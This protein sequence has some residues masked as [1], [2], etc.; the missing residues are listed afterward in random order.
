[1]LQY[2]SDNLPVAALKFKASAFELP[3]FNNGECFFFCPVG[4]TSWGNYVPT[5]NYSTKNSTT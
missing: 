3:L 4:T 2:Q 1:M 5:T